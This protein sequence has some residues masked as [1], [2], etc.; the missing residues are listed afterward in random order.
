V[1]ARPMRLHWSPRSP[2][3][4]KVLVAAHEAGLGDRIELLRTV[5]AS[6]APHPGLLR[7]NPLGKL[8]TLVLPDGFA[9]FDS[10][11]IVEYFAMLAPKSGLLPAE[12]AE[13]LAALRHESLGDGLLDLM[14]LWREEQRRSAAMQ[15]Q[16]LLAACALKFQHVINFLEAGVGDLETRPFDIGHIT[17]GCALSYVGFRFPELEWKAQH[18]RLARWLDDFSQRPAV[19]A[20]PVVD[21]LDAPM[22][23]STY[24]NAGAV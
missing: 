14:L 19:L 8:P 18:P 20:V 5:V 2:F 21:D 4:R 10:T 6:T 3:V 13:R 11:V 16:A 12:P 15:S 22:Q 24:A 1:S 9:V 23:P 17:I 7:D